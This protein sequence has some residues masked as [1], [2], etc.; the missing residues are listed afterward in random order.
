MALGHGLRTPNEGFD[1][2]NPELLGLVRLI[3][4]IN[5]GAFGVFLVQWVP[6]PCFSLLNNYFYIKLSLYIHIPNTGLGFEVGLQRIR[7]LDFVCPCSEWKGSLFWMSF[8]CHF[9]KALSLA[10]GHKAVIIVSVLTIWVNQSILYKNSTLD[11]DLFWF[12][13]LGED[14]SEINS[15]NSQNFGI[16][17]WEVYRY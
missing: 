8:F 4:Q 16:E 15:N 9:Q 17:L 10:K 6:F 13:Y 3:G 1:H 12:S 14:I 7:D 11:D 5:S 2:W